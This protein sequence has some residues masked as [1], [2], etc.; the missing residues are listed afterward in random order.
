[1]LIVEINVTGSGIRLSL[2]K[3]FKIIKHLFLIREPTKKPPM[4]PS[5]QERIAF[6]A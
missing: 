4:P 1:V 5:L 2:K 3:G 6:V